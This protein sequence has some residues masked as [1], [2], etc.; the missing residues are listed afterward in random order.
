MNSIL[1]L[2]PSPTNVHKALACLSAMITF[3]P[4]V[5]PLGQTLQR[6]KPDLLICDLG[7]IEVSGLAVA[8]ISHAHSPDT[9]ILFTGPPICRLQTLRL[10]EQKR[11]AAFL[12]KPWHLG[13]IHDVIASLLPSAGKRVQAAAKRTLKQPAPSR[14]NAVTRHPQPKNP[15]I[16]VSRYRMEEQIGEGGSGRV[17]R[18]HDILLDMPIAIKLLLPALYRDAQALGDL[19]SEA[20]IC[21]SLSHPNIVRLYNL[22]QLDSRYML[23]ME[24]ID[25]PNLYT[26]LKPNPTPPRTEYRRI[27]EAV[28]AALEH[29][30]GR[31]VIHSD[32][33]PANI[34]IT[35]AGTPKLIDFG[36]ATLAN[37]QAAP[38]EL[39]AGTPSYMSPEQ[40]RGEP[41]TPAT[42]IFA[43]GVLAFQMLTGYL[44]QNADATL[45]DLA[46]R[47]RP[48]LRGIAEAVAAVIRRALT[49]DP[50]DRWPTVGAFAQALLH[51]VEE[52]A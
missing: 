20:R 8:E 46:T 13:D 25:G 45:A 30:H 27:V 34:L 24:Y 21:M 48:P 17:F 6:L 11:V 43:F 37:Q 36:I 26:V 35:S 33:T 5:G 19:Q 51:T 40:L 14:I 12:P 4:S 52:P 22:D 23:V 10:I 50:A 9:Q 2:D 44:P 18:A 42:D 47:P 3:L 1:V 41:V 15:G 29:A 16:P 49:F 31:G 38:G 28:A 7:M 39:I 32:L